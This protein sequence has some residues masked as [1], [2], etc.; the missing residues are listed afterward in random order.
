MTGP[1]PHLEAIFPNRA[2]AG[3]GPRS[4]PSTLYNCIAYAACDK[5]RKWR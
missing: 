1:L 3:Y 4:E 2:A 5:T